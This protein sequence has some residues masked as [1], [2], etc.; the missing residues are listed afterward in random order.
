[1]L[2]LALGI[3]QFAC[4]WRLCGANETVMVIILSC[5]DTFRNMANSAT[6]CTE[7][8]VK[9]CGTCVG[10][11][12]SSYDGRGTDKHPSYIYPAAL[13]FGQRRTLWNSSYVG[14]M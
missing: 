1:M 13:N 2:E 3:I 7:L 4:R 11:L 8:R 12:R 14:P 6:S 10:C 5:S 9:D